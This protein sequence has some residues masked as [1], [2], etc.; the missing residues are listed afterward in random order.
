MRELAGGRTRIVTGHILEFLQRVLKFRRRLGKADFARRRVLPCSEDGGFENAHGVAELRRSLHRLTLG[1]RPPAE[2]A[3]ADHHGGDSD[4][5]KNGLVRKNGLG[6]MGQRV[7]DL[8]CLQF[9]ARNMLW[10]DSVSTEKY[11]KPYVNTGDTTCACEEASAFR[12]AK[13]LKIPFAA[14]GTALTRRA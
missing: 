8:V 11:G 9:L 12:A 1:I 6:A 13:K 2:H 7:L 3:E 14:H 4:V 5:D 10:H